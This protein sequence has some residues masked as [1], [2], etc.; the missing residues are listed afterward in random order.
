MECKKIIYS[1]ETIGNVVQVLYNLMPECSVFTFTGTLGAGKTTLVQHLLRHCGIKEV[2]TS[3][4]FTYVNI[5]TNEQGKTFY[6]FDLYRMH[7]LQDF[8]DAGFEEYLYQPNSWAFIE[9]PEIIMP[10]LTHRVCHVHITYYD[11]QRMLTY[12]KI[13]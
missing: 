3:P 2:I 10:L 1:L 6:H 12:E 4:T 9:W 11:R 7:S 13:A 5:Y 8:L